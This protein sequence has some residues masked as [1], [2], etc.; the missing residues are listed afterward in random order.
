MKRAGVVCILFLAFAGLADSAY[1]AQHEVS[2]TPLLCNINNLS[3]CN[4][5]AT[6]PY[7]HLF[8][9]PLAVYGIVFYGIIFVL[10]ALELVIFDRL[11]R[12]FLQ[13]MAFIG[14]IASLYFT[15]IQVFV[16]GAL[17]VYCLASAGIA[18]LMMIFATVIEPVRGTAKHIPP[19][20]R[21]FSMPPAS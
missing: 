4:I 13:G 7:S 5:V 1:I 9:I 3:G 10:A 17:C 6:S 18:L 21:H 8:G 12:R 20:S 11:L 15:L 2:G 14:V 19:P 16:I